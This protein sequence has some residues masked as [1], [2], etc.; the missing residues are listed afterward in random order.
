[1]MEQK[2][3]LSKERPKGSQCKTR[4]DRNEKK[5][6]TETCLIIKDLSRNFVIAES[7]QCHSSSLRRGEN[8]HS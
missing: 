1:M 8:E 6:L 5:D 2:K 3:L 7:L 4:N